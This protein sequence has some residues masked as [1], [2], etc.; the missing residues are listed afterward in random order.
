MR[1]LIITTLMLLGLAGSALGQHRILR[2]NSNQA[3]GQEPKAVSITV[4]WDDGEDRHRL[5]SILAQGPVQ[6]FTRNT[7]SWPTHAQVP[8]LIV[9]TTSR[10]W[11]VRYYSSRLETATR[12]GDTICGHQTAMIQTGQSAIH[13]SSELG[14]ALKV[15][16]KRDDKVEISEAVSVDEQVDFD[17]RT[18]ELSGIEE[19]AAKAEAAGEKDYARQIWRLVRRWQQAAANWRG[20]ETAAEPDGETDQ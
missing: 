20:A 6:F 5:S 13:Y 2:L 12:D 18:V 17:P 1:K 7:V 11:W 16:T 19:A 10:D 9:D 15:V 14:M 3:Q 4:A 8:L